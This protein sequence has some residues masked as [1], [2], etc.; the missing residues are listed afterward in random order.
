M[1]GS[2]LGMMYACTPFPPFAAA[3]SFRSCSTLA[4][5]FAE[6][7]TPDFWATASEVMAAVTRSTRDDAG[8]LGA[9]SKDCNQAKVFL[10]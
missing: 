7:A 10:R 1:W 8:L 9:C 6:E 3:I 2:S 5:P 4:S